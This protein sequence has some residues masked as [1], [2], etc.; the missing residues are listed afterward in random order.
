VRQD[1]TVTQARI[2][3]LI[4]VSRDQ[5]A[6]LVG[7]KIVKA[8]PVHGGLTNTIHKVTTAEGASFGVKH[9][10]GGRDWFETELTTLT[11]LH[12]TLPVPEVVH[13]DDTRHVIVYRWIDGITL[14]DVRRQGHTDGFAA[15]AQPLGTALAYLAKSDAT[16]PYE[17]T[18]LLESRYEQLTL[19][20]ARERIG[21]AL[22]DALRR[23]LEANEPALAFGTV[24]LTHGDLGH[25]NVIVGRAGGRWRING[26]ID[27]E[28]AS[29]GSP[30]VDIGSLFRYGSTRHDPTFRA[31][32][33]RGYRDA[34]GVLPEGWYLTARLLD[35]LELVA[36]LDEDQEIRAVFDDCRQL[37]AKLVGEL[38]G[39]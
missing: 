1:P 12:N 37:I 31:G 20:R 21:P 36:V 39:E 34:G 10:A 30:L 8:E 29:T 38:E 11:L 22:A 3:P 7:G 25:R 24:C 13:A 32:F 5:L 23:Q 16:E 19:G 2:F 17:L 28:T 26:V 6:E 33:E 14:L 18:Q 15:L 4:D 35:V 27:W 9:Y